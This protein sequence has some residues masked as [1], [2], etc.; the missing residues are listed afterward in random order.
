MGVTTDE[1]ET[2][3][4]PDAYL[5]NFSAQLFMH[6]GVS[7]SDARQAADVLARSDLRGIDVRRV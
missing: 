2:F 3:L 4:F 7:E 1:R 6:F 5:R